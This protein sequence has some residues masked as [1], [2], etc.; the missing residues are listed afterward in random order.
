MY[1]LLIGRYLG[2]PQ[3]LS[4]EAPYL[5]SALGQDTVA[6][7]LVWRMTSLS[8]LSV[9]VSLL[10]QE[11]SILTTTGSSTARGATY[12]AKGMSQVAISACNSIIDCL[13][14][15]GYVH[16]LINQIRLQPMVYKHDNWD[17]IKAEKDMKRREQDSDD[18]QD[19]LFSATLKLC[20][21]LARND[22]GLSKLIDSGILSKIKSLPGK[23]IPVLSTSVVSGAGEKSAAA[24]NRALQFRLLPLLQLLQVLGRT[25]IEA[26]VASGWRWSVVETFATLLRKWRPCFA[27]LLRLQLHSLL[28][29]QLMEAIL[30]VLVS[31]AS[32]TSRDIALKNKPAV[33]PSTSVVTVGALDAY[34]EGTNAPCSIW[35]SVLTD[36]V[37]DAY[38]QDV[39]WI[40]STL[41]TFRIL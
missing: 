7:P 6:G 35:S 27:M 19:E 22:L 4:R 3:I 9:I 24:C 37:G 29:L 40:L 8:V 1:I 28:G 10:S 14:S 11:R 36:V 13:S 33:N 31:T 39:A 26:G 12:D 20:M 5:A 38:L 32:F 15:K 17:F 34:V 30:S 23:S 21:E 2:R 25:N 41:G 18:V 16:A